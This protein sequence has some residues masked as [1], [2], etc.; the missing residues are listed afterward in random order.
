VSAGCRAGSV[1]AVGDGALS[2][3][4]FSQVPQNYIDG[5]AIAF[6]VFRVLHATFYL[7][8]RPMLRSHAWRLGMI[9]VISL[10]ILAAVV[11][12]PKL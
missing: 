9:C 11:G 10:F 6:V 2:S 4:E 3:P 12:Q 8:N 7:I 5:I 1:C